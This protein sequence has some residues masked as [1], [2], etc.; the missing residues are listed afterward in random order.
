MSFS[1]FIKFILR[2]FLQVIMNVVDFLISVYS[3]S[4]PGK[5]ADFSIVILHP[6]T[7]W[8][9]FMRSKSFLMETLG[10]LRYKILSLTNRDSLT[11]SFSI[12]IPFISFSCLST[13][14]RNP[15]TI[16]NKSGKSGDTLS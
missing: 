6:A 10:S 16:M 8:K 11:S 1:S 12:C 5:A 2:H 9:V 7:L 14:A 3:L 13:L 15:Y 4:L